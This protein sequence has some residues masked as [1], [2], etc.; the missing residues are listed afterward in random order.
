VAL[1]SLAGA[2]W[3]VAST[4]AREKQAMEQALRETARALSLVVDR[5]L[6]RRE[7][8]AW[9]LATS[10]SLRVG[11]WLSFHA[12]AVEATAAIGG[13]VVLFGPDGMLDNTSQPAGAE[14]P[15]RGEER[16]YV[17][18]TGSGATISDLFRGPATGRWLVALSVPVKQPGMA[19]HGISI[20]VLPEH[21]QQVIDDQKLP[22]GWIA[23]VVDRQGRV[24]ARHPD[25]SKWIGH[26]ATPELAAQLG[27]STEGF[28]HSH[29]LDGAATT[30]FFSTSPNYQWA[31][32][33]TVPDAQL[34]ASLRQSVLEASAVA[35]VLL[36]LSA[37]AALTVG[38]KIAL[39]ARR[40]QAAA[41]ALKAGTPIVYAAAGVTELDVAG[42]TLAQAGT[43]LV[44]ANRALEQREQERRQAEERMAS[45]LAR[46]QLLDQITRA[47]GDRLDLHSVFQVVANSI[48]QQ[49]QVA[50]CAIAVCD[51]IDDRLRVNAVAAG[52]E[53]LAARLCLTEQVQLPID[54][55]G[56]SRCMRGDL[57][58]EPDLAQLRAPLPQRLVDA[59]LHSAV[60]APLQAEGKVFGIVMA[61]RNAAHSFSSGDCEFM[62]QLSEHVALAAH[63]ARLHGALQTAYDELRQTQQIVLQQERLRAIGE[64]ASGIAHDFNNAISPVALYTESLLEKEV[65][66]S[67]RGRHQLETIQRAIDDVAKTVARMGEFYR[68]RDAQANHVAV[69]LNA[70]V[71]QVIEL[72]RPR[73]RDMAQQ[74]GIAIAV[75]TD[76]HV[77]LPP[78][79]AAEGEIREVLTNL[80]FNAVDAMPE[81]GTLTMSTRR[82]DDAEGSE[83]VQVEVS[84]S[85]IGMSEET[86]RRCLEPFFTTKGQRGT[87]LGL[88][89]VYGTMQ[90]HGAQMQIDS[91]PG[92]G[93]RMR[94]RFRPAGALE[95]PDTGWGQLAPAAG[96]RQLRILL[97]DDDAV[98][99]RTLIEIL[100]SE[101]HRVTAATGGQQG[102]AE[103]GAALARGEPFDVVI[104]D[105]GMPNVDGRQVAQAVKAAAP[106]T[107]VVM[108]T[109]W[110]RR[111]NEDGERPLHVDHLLSKPPRLAELRAALARATASN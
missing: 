94:L 4:Y 37:T 34:G 2:A 11:D 86:R 82:V 60:F 40:L 98:L 97:V 99:A 39:P 38:R 45:Q 20:V 31:F 27:A 68:P 104:T 89:M 69:D 70:L 29:S 72:T 78:V 13:W 48:A 87:G 18:T 41:E 56:L 103:F 59:G 3:A 55:D 19:E 107:P 54:P 95:Q 24:V 33:I 83:W 1:T 23:A 17:R 16:R 85:G 88:A 28:L 76:L 100:E 62:R 50:F 71:Q 93:T 91:T 67:A 79:L 81:G 30:A 35:L 46:M 15:K 110:G 106:G 47:I 26:P 108:L 109:G 14:L 8:V 12:Q 96:D 43:Q 44:E 105:L 36:A 57:V 7:A 92:E 61:A 21:L 90:R 66:L 10:P 32:V 49:L 84:D 9:T 22:P 77:P 58:H 102:I 42:A 6:G 51:D 75:D 74:A 5:E 73:W 65:G 64:M 52:S 25:P 80:V 101:G 53:A 63:Q 111:M